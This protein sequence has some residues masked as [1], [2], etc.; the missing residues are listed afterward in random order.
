MSTDVR[1]AQ[2]EQWCGAYDSWQLAVARKNDGYDMHDFAV[3]MIVDCLL[4][5]GFIQSFKS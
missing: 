2:E 4:I 3:N 1:R 5:L